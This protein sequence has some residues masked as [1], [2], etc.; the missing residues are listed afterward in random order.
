MLILDELGY[1]PFSK[2][3]AELLF[4]VVGRAYEQTS[5]IVTTNLPFEQW[6]E[7]LDRSQRDWHAHDDTTDVAIAAPAHDRIHPPT[8]PHNADKSHW[9][10]AQ[11]S[12]PPGSALC[13]LSQRSPP[14]SGAKPR[15]APISDE[16]L[17][18]VS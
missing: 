4:D 6:T 3:G 17:F 16:T 14:G 8:R 2:A 10:T 7:V 15:P 18:L 5:L 1:V 9:P 13:S 12:P 11:A